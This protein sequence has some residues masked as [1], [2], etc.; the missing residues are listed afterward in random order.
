MIK[1][2]LSKVLN[3]ISTFANKTK[4]H[5][6]GT[7]NKIKEHMRIRVYITTGCWL[8]MYFSLIAISFLFMLATG[9]PAPFLFNF[10]ATTYFIGMRWL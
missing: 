1:N 7:Y 6:Q 5:L 2:I 10:F 4:E 3:K 9:N 8:F